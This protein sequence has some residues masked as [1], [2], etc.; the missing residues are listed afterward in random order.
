MVITIETM[1]II[2]VHKSPKHSHQRVN[3]I[4]LGNSNRHKTWQQTSQKLAFVPGNL[5]K[6]LTCTR[7]NN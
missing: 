5:Y 4:L 6:F 2:E 3:I 7:H 1:K